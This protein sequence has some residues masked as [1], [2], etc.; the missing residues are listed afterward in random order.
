VIPMVPNLDVGL[1]QIMFGFT[2]VVCKYRF[3]KMKIGI[4]HMIIEK[5]CE[6]VH[7]KYSFI[8]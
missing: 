8:V 5:N 2:K 4:E 1:R 7:K 6:I 3:V